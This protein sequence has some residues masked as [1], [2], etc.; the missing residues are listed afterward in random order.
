M[1]MVIAPTREDISSWV[2]EVVWGKDGRTLMRNAWQKTGYDWFKG[3]ACD[4]EEVAAEDAL[5][6]IK[7]DDESD[8]DDYLDA[9]DMVEDVLGLGEVN[10]DES[11]DED[12]M[13]GTA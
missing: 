8:S 11:N 9:A 1:G 5:G 13:W 4:G 10:D 3:D 7:I 6:N 12:M 2:A